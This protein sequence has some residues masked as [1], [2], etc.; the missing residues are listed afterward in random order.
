MATD[1][2][3]S[4]AMESGRSDPVGVPTIDYDP[5]TKEAIIRV[6]EVDAEIRNAGNLVWLSYWKMWAA[7]RYK[8]VKTIL[9]DRI[10]FS[11]A[12]RPFSHPDRPMP[13]L[14]VTE[15]QPSHTITRRALNHVF[16]PARVAEMAK[17]FDAVAEGFVERL[18]T[19][20]PIEAVE[21]LARPYIL[22]VFGDA[23]GFEEEGRHL[24]GL[25]G[26]GSI[27]TFGP[28]TDFAIEAF[29]ASIPSFEWV[30]RQCEG[31]VLT[32]GRLGERVWEAVEK[33]DVAPDV[34]PILMKTI[35]AAGI[36]TTIA[37]I[38]NTLTG[39]AQFQGQWETLRANPE[40]A[41]NAFEEGHRWHS[42][43]RWLGRTAVNDVEVEG[44]LIR[45]GDPVLAFVSAS[46][47][48]E[49]V[50]P[51]ADRFDITRKVGTHLGFGSGI[52]NCVG[53]VLARY[54]YNALL[55]AMLKR[56]KR[57]E[58]VSPPVPLVSNLSTYASL[59]IV[60]H[61]E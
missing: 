39:F 12:K 19:G 1:A 8:P 5:L 22:A 58:L 54:E 29:E 31:K 61:P 16:A 48:D 55:Q 44:Q 50:W 24:F 27:N 10:N 51:D 47:R 7:A 2:N 45:A 56:V 26:P 4:L 15:D 52:H 14:A 20:R 6:L 38:V 33:G 23:M 18:A 53:Q 11:S 32:R 21:E 3:N 37:I 9:Q 59:P 40:L 34:A 36:D 41:N 49:T 25:F 17:G 35:M 46:G 57:I 13:E 30:D 42:P 28:E 43:A 60:L